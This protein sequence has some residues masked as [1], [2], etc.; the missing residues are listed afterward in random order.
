[1]IDCWHQVH[2]AW[3]HPNCFDQ[4]AAALEARSFPVV[5][6]RNAVAASPSQGATYRDDVKAIHAVVLPLLDGGTRVF[7]VAHSYGGIPGCALTEGQSVPERA[8]RGAKGGIVGI[9]LMAAFGL[10]A[11][12]MSMARI[13][14]QERVRQVREMVHVKVRTLPSPSPSRSRWARIVRRPLADGLPCQ[15]DGWYIKHA[16]K[17]YFYNDVSDDIAQRYIEKCD[18]FPETAVLEPVHFCVADLQVPSFY[19]LCESDEV[20]P[21]A[22]QDLMARANADMK[23]VSA[24]SELWSRGSSRG[25]GGFT[26]QH[27]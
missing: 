24:P 9:M 15:G 25:R 5:A 4:L 6:V 27:D 21:P 1:M 16:A 20:L 22:V 26:E 7:V 3:H 13:L 10:P 2:G 23:I 19:L 18:F 8:A 12:G 14:M 11:R 17:A